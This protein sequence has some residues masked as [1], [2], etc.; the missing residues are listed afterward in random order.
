MSI[1]R[2][3][4]EVVKRKAGSGF[5]GSSLPEFV[6]I[7]TDPKEVDYCMLSC[8]DSECK[9]YANLEVVKE[10]GSPTGEYLYH[11]SECQM[12]TACPF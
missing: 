9:E 1:R 2:Y 7:P 6:K 3:I 8:G 10:D 5:V 12:E 4:G 11:I